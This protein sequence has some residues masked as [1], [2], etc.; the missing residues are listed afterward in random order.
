VKVAAG[1]DLATRK[2]LWDSTACEALMLREHRTGQTIK[3][4]TKV[5]IKVQGAHQKMS[6]LQAPTHVGDYPTP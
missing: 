1:L 2:T 4:A 5:A 3:V 6:K